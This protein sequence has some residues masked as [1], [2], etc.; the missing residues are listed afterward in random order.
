MACE[1]PNCKQIPGFDGINGYHSVEIPAPWHN[2]TNRLLYNPKSKVFVL[3]PNSAL[4]FVARQQA[5]AE[6]LQQRNVLIE[7]F[8]TNPG[9]G[10][11]KLCLTNKAEGKAGLPVLKVQEA[12]I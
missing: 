6:L 7:L 5:L 1:N 12:G 10:H 11:E 3:S 4:T 9:I 8:T 2:Q